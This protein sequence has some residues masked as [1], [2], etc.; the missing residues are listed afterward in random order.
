ML[1][2]EMTV[3]QFYGVIM[4]ALVFAL[5]GLLMIREYPKLENNKQRFVM[6]AGAFAGFGLPAIIG[7]MALT[8]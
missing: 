7:L 6:W 8:E 4:L 2:S 1:V 5:G 3:V